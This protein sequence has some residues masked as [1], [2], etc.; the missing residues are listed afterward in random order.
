MQKFSSSLSKKLF[1]LFFATFLS[2]RPCFLTA[3][4]VGGKAS[5]ERYEQRKRSSKTIAVS[6]AT[7]GI[8][9]EGE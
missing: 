5:S 8:F 3:K 6:I 4:R 2:V 1:L 9:K 7:Q